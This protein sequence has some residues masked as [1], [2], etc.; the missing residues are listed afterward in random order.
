MKLRGS[1]RSGLARPKATRERRVGVDD[2]RRRVR[3]SV[4]IKMLFPQAQPSPASQANHGP[5]LGQLPSL[6]FESLASVRR[7]GSGLPLCLRGGLG[8]V[9]NRE[10]AEGSDCLIV[11]SALVG[12]GIGTVIVSMG[13]IPPSLSQ[14]RVGFGMLM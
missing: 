14:S 12:V 1:V 4:E 10:R 3:L 5:V 13:H 2:P 9:R 11:L 6:P 7:A 8:K